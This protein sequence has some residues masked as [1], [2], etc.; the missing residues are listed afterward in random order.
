MALTRTSGSPEGSLEISL[1]LGHGVATTA[2][3]YSL[4][5]PISL[6]AV[7]AGV[8]MGRVRCLPLHVRCLERRGDGLR[9]EGEEP[10]LGD[11]PGESAHITVL[12]RILDDDICRPDGNGP[13][14]SAP[15]HDAPNGVPAP[16][17]HLTNIIS[18]RI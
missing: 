14:G 1:F 17:G 10:G 4:V 6:T 18:K 2:F 8:L 3:A 9:P 15:E 16:L 7:S 13:D 12:H 11:S 5:E